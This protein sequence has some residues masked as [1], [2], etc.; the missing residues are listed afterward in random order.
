MS[1]NHL[2]VLFHKDMGMT[3]VA[4]RTRL[5]LSRA[6]HLLSSTAMPVAQVARE[7]GFGD[8]SYFTRAFRRTFGLSRGNSCDRTK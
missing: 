5:R 2:S 6:R 1:A 8:A 3:L 4:Y 7:V